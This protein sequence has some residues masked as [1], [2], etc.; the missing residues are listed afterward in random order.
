MTGSNRA[1]MR[2]SAS[3]CAGVIVRRPPGN[4]ETRSSASRCSCKASTAGR[5]AIHRLAAVALRSGSANDRR[6]DSNRSRN[7]RSATAA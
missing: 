7:L 1:S 3:A 4:D 2:I 5:L 6:H